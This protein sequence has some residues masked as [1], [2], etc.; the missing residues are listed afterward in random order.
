[1]LVAAGT[2]T[3]PDGT[4]ET[5]YA[6]MLKSKIH[7]ASVSQAD[8]HYVG[9]LTVYADLME[10]ADL[11][12]ADPAGSGKS[13]AAAAVG[14]A[15]R[16]LGLLSSGRLNEVS[17]MDLVGATRAETGTLMGGAATRSAGCVLMIKDADAWRQR[18]A[19][20]VGAVQETDR[21][22]RRAAR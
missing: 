19:R 21:V 8:L 22:P 2:R 9:S 13:R 18:P 16:E 7:R 17:A 11:V 4:R 6:A 10:A 1:M 20:L 12:F 3:G 14:R 5:R 15:Y